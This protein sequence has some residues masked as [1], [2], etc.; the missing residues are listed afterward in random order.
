M[1]VLQLMLLLLSF[2]IVD[3]NLRIRM[4]R[5]LTDIAMDFVLAARRDDVG[6]FFHQVVVDEITRSRAFSRCYEYA[7]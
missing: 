1:Q 4:L 2:S 3:I 7:K 5:L 6:Q